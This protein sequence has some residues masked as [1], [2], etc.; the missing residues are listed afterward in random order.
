M[1]STIDKF[2]ASI[3][4]PAVMQGI[5]GGLAPFGITANTTVGNVVTIAF[6][7]ILVWLWPNKAKA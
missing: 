5:L 7:A 2:F 3:I 1:F 4:G 6:G